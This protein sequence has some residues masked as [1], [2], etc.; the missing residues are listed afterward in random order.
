MPNKFISLPAL[1]SA[2]SADGDTVAGLDISA[3]QE[4]SWTLVELAK[5]VASRLVNAVSTGTLHVTGAATL[6][7]TLAAAGTTVT[8]LHATGA[9]TLDSTLAA[10]AST[11]TGLLDVNNDT[12]R[13]R[14]A[15]TPASAA[16][17]GTAGDHCWDS[18]FLYVCV[19]SNTWKRVAIATW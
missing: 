12:V 15:K 4:I 9:A 11:I 14:T 6:D 5:A 13:F 7:S 8:T 18:G 16:A 3:K 1:T 17:T 10:G 2:N 19:S